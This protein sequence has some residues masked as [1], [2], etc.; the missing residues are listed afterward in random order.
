MYVYVIYMSCIVLNISNIYR[1][2]VLFAKKVKGH[3][4]LMKL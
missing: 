3:K 1:L 4:D 2:F